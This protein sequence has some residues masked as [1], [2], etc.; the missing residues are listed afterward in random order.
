MF[1][2]ACRQS[3]PVRPQTLMTAGRA[4]Q[5]LISLS[6]PFRPQKMEGGKYRSGDGGRLEK[7]ARNSQESHMHHII[8]PLFLLR[9]WPQNIQNPEIDPFPLRFRWELLRR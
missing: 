1:A 3:E 4:G 7:G 8:F 9:R 5:L 2:A 6:L